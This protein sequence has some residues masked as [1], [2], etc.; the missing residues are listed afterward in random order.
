MKREKEIKKA[1]FSFGD[2]TIL[3]ILKEENNKFLGTI[4]TIDFLEQKESDYFSDETAFFYEV[5]FRRSQNIFH[6]KKQ[7]LNK[8]YKITQQIKK[9]YGCYGN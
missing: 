2:S 9:I 4:Y 6:T 7:A 5:F 8:F 3:Y 1:S